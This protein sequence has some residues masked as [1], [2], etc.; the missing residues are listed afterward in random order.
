M[1]EFR[2]E[3]IGL[4]AV[5]YN[6]L[7][8][9]RLGSSAYFQIISRISGGSLRML[10]FWAAEPGLGSASLLPPFAKIEVGATSGLSTMAGNVGTLEF[11]AKARLC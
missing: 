11:A 6:L 8:Y 2:A 4:S 1:C 7:G 9:V 5:D 3:R 10:N